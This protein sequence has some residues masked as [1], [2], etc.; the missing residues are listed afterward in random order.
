MVKYTVLILTI[1]LFQACS[2][3]TASKASQATTKASETSMDPSL[4]TPTVKQVQSNHDNT[5]S[6]WSFL[7]SETPMGDVKGKI[8]VK[9]ENNALK[10]I[11]ESESGESAPIE[12]FK[13]ENNKMTGSFYYDGNQIKIDAS[14]EGDQMKGSLNASGMA[15]YKLTGKK[16]K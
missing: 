7:V 10:G 2:P 14:I 15:N 1:L 12:N 5:D 6:E 8:L 13:I 11:L 16:I 3:K 9:N 4:S